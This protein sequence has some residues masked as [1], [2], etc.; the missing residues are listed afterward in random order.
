[1]RKSSMRAGWRKA[2][3]IRSAVIATAVVALTSSAS[4]SVNGPRLPEGPGTASTNAAPGTQ[5]EVQTK[6]QKKSEKKSAKS[7]GSSTEITAIPFGDKNNGRVYNASGG[8][9]IA[10]GRVLICDNKTSDA[11]LELRLDPSG[12]K[13]G[14]LVRRPLAGATVED[15]EGMTRVELDGHSFFIVSS[16]FNRHNDTVGG[17]MVA[18]EGSADGFLRVDEAADGSLTAQNMPGVREWLVAH[19]PDLKAVA[20]AVPDDG[21]INIEGLTWDPN[22]GAILFGV[23]TPLRSGRPLVL[24]VRLKNGGNPWTVDSLEALPAIVLDDGQPPAGRGIRALAYAPKRHLF[25]LGLGKAISGTDAT[26]AL[27]TW[28]GGEDGKLRLRPHA[29]FNRKLKLEGMAHAIVHGKDALVI[30]DDAGG[31]AVIPADDPRLQ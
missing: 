31:Y 8:V 19:Y 13:V 11:L 23:R 1:M 26:F 9:E 7:P 27:Y 15:A 3:S 10:E 17:K 6:E 12:V 24:P 30:L 25:V 5:K 2:S 14:P 29:T 4:A 28:D 21:G 18:L 16:S 20:E 22:R